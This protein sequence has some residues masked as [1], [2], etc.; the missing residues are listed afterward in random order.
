MSELLS[1]GGYAAFV[2]GAYGLVF[3]GL[4]GLAAAS[5]EARRRAQAALAE[6]EG[7]SP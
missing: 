7:E 3:L 4:G 2:W 5:W 1:M 6:E